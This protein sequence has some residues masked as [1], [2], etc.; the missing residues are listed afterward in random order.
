MELKPS[1]WVVALVGCFQFG[2]LEADEEVERILVFVCL[3]VCVC[4]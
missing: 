2:K 1:G 3:C 4:G